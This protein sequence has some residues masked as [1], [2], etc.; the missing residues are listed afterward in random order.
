[1]SNT[2]HTYQDAIDDLD[3]NLEGLKDFLNGKDRSSYEE[4][5]KYTEILEIVIEY[6]KS[7]KSTSPGPVQTNSK[8][9]DPQ[10]KVVN[11]D[12]KDEEVDFFKDKYKERDDDYSRGGFTFL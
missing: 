8:P 4:E 12:Y 7:K 11:T 6:L 2:G 10:V 5:Y 3:A 1:V 9:K